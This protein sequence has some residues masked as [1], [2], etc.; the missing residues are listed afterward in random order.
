MPLR[1]GGEVIQEE[2][3][4]RF[5]GEILGAGEVLPG[6][7][8]LN[9]V[10]DALGSLSNP[11]QTPFPDEPGTSRASQEIPELISSGGVASIAPNL[12]NARQLAI[13]TAM[14]TATDPQEIA[15]MLGEDPDVSFTF[16]SDGAIVV[17]NQKAGIRSLI[18][19]PGLSGMDAAQLGGTALA[20]FPGERIA[21]AAS[22]LA[23]KLLSRNSTNIPSLGVRLGTSATT[24]AA[25]ETGLQFQQ[26]AAGGDFNS[27]EIALSA[28]I[29]A[30][31]ELGIK[32]LINT[33]TATKQFVRELAGETPDR[34]IR[35]KQF[36]REV[37]PRFLKSGRPAIVTTTDT[38]GDQFTPRTMITVKES[39]RTRFFGIGKKV[40][41]IQPEQ[42]QEITNAILKEEG[43]DET[44]NYGR[45]IIGSFRGKRDGELARATRGRQTA[46]DI[47]DAPGKPIQTPKALEQ[48]D[49]LLTLERN[50]LSEGNPELI[51]R[52]EN[53]RKD[54]SSGQ[55]FET[56]FELRK[57]LNISL[58]RENALYNENAESAIKDVTKA[59]GLDMSQAAK[60]AGPEARQGWLQYNR[61]Y[62]DDLGKVKNTALGKLLL[63]KNSPLTSDMVNQVLNSN[64]PKL[65]RQLFSRLGKD[66]QANLR[67]DFLQ[68][69][70]VKA[71]GTQNLDLKK[72]RNILDDPTHSAKMKIYF[73]VE[74]QFN[75]FMEYLRLT[76]REI[77]KP[78]V[79]SGNGSGFSRLLGVES[80]INGFSG[81]KGRMIESAPIRVLLTRLNGAKTNPRLTEKIMAELRPLITA[82]MRNDDVEIEG[83]VKS[84]E[85]LIRSITS[86]A[87]EGTQNLF[88]AGG[89]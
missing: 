41:K 52:L 59:L 55:G 61:I 45:S 83:P 25:T 9:A 18:N 49:E 44:T 30:V 72:F 35:G 76:Q 7:T 12:S 3:K 47:I 21:N 60:A 62:K 75:G 26:E 48:I 64:K 40:S 58:P 17:N 82:S 74:S 11:Q 85:E 53:I 24:N 20:F 8:P 23:A 32:P 13:S 19:K 42:R 5:G 36:A 34:V 73:T 50:A 70:V 81:V 39:E 68:K 27:G 63:D 43:V 2:S 86:G 37:A 33:A 38:V 56:L 79:S 15:Q 84:T 10:Q 1:F 4:L 46:F 28:G 29:P 54:L 65:L 71:G 87:I 22:G 80:L 14:L 89:N 16:A 78:L 69:A 66:G 88:G 77:S 6:S 57:R 31:T 51:K 67:R